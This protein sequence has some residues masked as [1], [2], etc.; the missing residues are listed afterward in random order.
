MG[1]RYPKITEIWLRKQLLTS[2]SL[3][4]PQKLDFSHIQQTAG[5][6]GASLRPNNSNQDSVQKP[7][8]NL[9]FWMTP[10]KAYVPIQNIQDLGTIVTFQLY[11]VRLCWMTAHICAGIFNKPNLCYPS[12]TK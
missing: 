8:L 6:K 11:V 4:A 10:L 9:E 2:L 5:S 12:K 3:S 7:L 1:F